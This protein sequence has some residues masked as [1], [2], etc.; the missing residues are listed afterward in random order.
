MI[1]GTLS[2]GVKMPLVGLGTYK[3][4]IDEIPLVLDSALNLG[5]R[6][7]D[8]A[9]YYGNE[10]AIGRYLMLSG[11]PREEVF[12]STKMD[13]EFL[14]Y[15]LN[16]KGRCK[17]LPIRRES[18]RNAFFR[19]LERLHTN[20]VDMYMLHAPI[21]KYY[22]YWGNEVGKL[23]KEGYIRSIGVCSFS[24]RD[25]ELFEA[26]LGF[27]PMM[28]QIEISPYNTNKE[29]ITLCKEKTVQVEAFATFGTT[30]KN[31]EA[32]KDLLENEIILAL[33]K[34]YN[35]STSQVILRWVLEQGVSVIPKARSKE[36]L[37]ENIDVLD[38]ELSH[39]DMQQID[40][41]DKSIFHRYFR[42]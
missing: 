17:K 7:I 42:Q 22:K 21:P 18:L 35:K 34:K 29:I 24:K 20:Y 30:K 26:E 6:K 40:T 9:R 37:R 31:P 33:S 3:I 8:T 12:I 39:E 36:H 2:N 13:V 11:V 32:A 23:Y 16:V 28:N 4:P 10:D 14:Y 27:V 15:S 1:Y 41:L 19:Q 38:F 5:Y 25:F